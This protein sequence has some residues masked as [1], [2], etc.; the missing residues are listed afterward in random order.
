MKKK[1]LSHLVE[2][3]VDVDGAIEV[4][5]TYQRIKNIDIVKSIH[6]VGST[7]NYEVSLVIYDNY[8][9]NGFG[10]ITVKSIS[11]NDNFLEFWDNISYFINFS[12]SKK[13]DS[14]Q[15]L[16]S[17]NC[18]ESEEVIYILNEML[19]RAKNNKELYLRE[20]DKK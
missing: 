5:E 16:D 12:K 9:K 18:D 15:K 8:H 20:G 7:R 2:N 6:Y 17:S 1:L 14:I 10:S 3:R 13:M 4:L 11:T 19:E